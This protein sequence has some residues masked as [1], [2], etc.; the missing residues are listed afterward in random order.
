MCDA[1]PSWISTTGLVGGKFF[2][3]HSRINTI[4]NFIQPP[5]LLEKRV[6]GTAPSL[7]AIYIIKGDHANLFRLMIGF[8]LQSYVDFKDVWVWCYKSGIYTE[9]SIFAV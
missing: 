5:S 7:S 1:W 9:N 3:N 8:S 4:I 6:P 2:K